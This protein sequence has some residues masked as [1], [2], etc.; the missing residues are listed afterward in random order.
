MSRRDLP[1][2][3][4][5]IVL[6]IAHLMVCRCLSLFRSAFRRPLGVDRRHAYQILAVTAAVQTAIAIGAP[7]NLVCCTGSTPF[8]LR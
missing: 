7:T 6:R 4:E 2:G 8:R 1:A 3:R 5:A